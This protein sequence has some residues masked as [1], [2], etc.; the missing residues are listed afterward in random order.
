MSIVHR[1]RPAI[2]FSLLG[3]TAGGNTSAQDIIEINDAQAALIDNTF[4]AAT[5]AANIDLVMVREGDVV[6]AG[7][8][9]VQL[10]DSVVR[11]EVRAAE[12]SATAARIAAQN[13]VDA[14]YARQSLE[15][16]KQELILSMQANEQF[17]GSVPSTEIQKLQLVVDQSQL[18][19][20]QAEQE[21]AIAAA[22]AKEKDAQMKISLAKLERHRILAPLGG[23][24]VQVD[25]RAGEWCEAGKPLIRLIST[26][27]IRIECFIDGQRHGA[28]LVGRSIEFRTRTSH[29]NDDPQI[30]TVVFVSP[31]ISAVTGQSKLWAELPNDDGR[32]RAGMRGSM[33]IL[34]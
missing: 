3:M 1:V 32:I 11:T 7:E 4:V 29:P 33:K 31:E 8:A 13:D 28:E 16:R 27:P 5:T 10:D 15:V 14:R 23:T 2:L 17:A 20:E 26:S 34:P 9:L 22:T 6:R 19:I 30:G 18:S 12:A 21:S 25:A 24:V